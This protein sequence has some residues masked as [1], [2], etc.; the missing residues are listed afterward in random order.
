MRLLLIVLLLAPLAAAGE[1]EEDE[2][3]FRELVRRLGAPSYDE[4]QTAFAHLAARSEK[5]SDRLRKISADDPEARRLLRELTRAARHLRLVLGAPTQP[6]AIGTPLVL[7]VRI[8]NDTDDTYFLPVT[9]TPDRRGTLSSLSIS[10]GGKTRIYLK[11]DQVEWST[12]MGAEPIIRPGE[13]MQATVRLADEHTPLRR[14]GELQVSVGYNNRTTQ[15]WRGPQRLEQQDAEP[16]RVVLRTPPLT[17]TAFGRKAAELEKALADRKKRA[18]A[19]AELSVRE[20][21][22]VLP[23]LRKFADDR[24]LR[25]AAVQRLGANGAEEDFPLLYKATRDPEANV[26]KAAVL[27]LANYRTS[28]AR[29]RL[30]ALAQ[31][32]EHKAHAIKALMQHKH[33]STINL[34][35]RIMR[36]RSEDRTVVADIQRALYEWTNISVPDKRSEVLAFERWW[37]KNRDRWTRENTSDK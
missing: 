3:K 36:N 20:D 7:K 1:K 4:R 19:I 31:D 29:R 26:R 12:A 8:I 33:P 15:R 37:V 6:L 5:I 23:L 22:A 35:I 9:H 17:V 24:Q 25:L 21:A 11:P 32:Q 27:G 14:P 30:V 13:F 2:K 34:F 18:G 28:E 16:A 10:F